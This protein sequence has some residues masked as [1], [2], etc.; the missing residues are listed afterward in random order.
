M[1]KKK[2][3]HH[4]NALDKRIAAE[5]VKSSSKQSAFIILLSCTAL[6]VIFALG[7]INSHSF[8]EI[9]PLTMMQNNLHRGETTETKNNFHVYYQLNNYKLAINVFDELENK[10]SVDSL[11]LG[12]SY[13]LVGENVNAKE[14]FEQI[15]FEENDLYFE[16]WYWYKNLALLKAGYTESALKALQF[17]AASDSDYAKE[18]AD[19]IDKL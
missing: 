11:Y 12:I 6:F 13:L 3:Q 2:L 15:E 14:V 17:I 9:Q 7:T 8:I 4:L 19:V 16:S 18:A 1:D 5:E 10:T